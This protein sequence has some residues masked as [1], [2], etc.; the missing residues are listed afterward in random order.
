MAE[1]RAGLVV[2]KYQIL[3]NSYLVVPPERNPGLDAVMETR[4]LAPQGQE[5]ALRPDVVRALCA[6]DYGVGSSGVVLGPLPGPEDTT[7]LHIYNEDGTRCNFSGNAIR[8]LARY[9]VERGAI[10]GTPGTRCMLGVVGHV[11]DAARPHAVTNAAEIEIAA[12]GGTQIRAFLSAPRIGRTSVVAAPGA[13]AEAARPA[14]APAADTWLHVPALAELGRRLPRP[15][16]WSSHAFVDMGNPHC[17]TFVPTLDDLPGDDFAD[18]P[19]SDLVALSYAGAGPGLAG[20]F[21]EGCN[22]QFAHVSPDGF[23]HLRTFERG[24]GPTKSSGSSSSAAAAAA[25]ARGLVGPQVRVAMVGGEIAIHLSGEPAAIVGIALG[26][27]VGRIGV[28]EVDGEALP[29]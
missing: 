19:S 28:I 14:S 29:G 9:M 25:Y 22:L 10:S 17:V 3:G 8:M 16:D 11:G 13:V 26:S 15:R 18:V 2:Y 12:P 23:L 7:L 5:R 4:E 6:L 21:P 24:G 1:K 20:I 27:A